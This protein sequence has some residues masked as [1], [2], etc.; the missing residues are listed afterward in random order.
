MKSK[1]CGR[2]PVQ[3]FIDADEGQV[4]QICRKAGWR[5]NGATGSKGNLCISNSIMTVYNVQSVSKGG[6]KVKRA[7]PCKHKVVVACNK[8]ENQ[9]FPVHYEKYQGQKP[10]KEPCM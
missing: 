1:L 9:C 7:K 10:G 4:K 8:V 5:V 3:S 2:V 6:C